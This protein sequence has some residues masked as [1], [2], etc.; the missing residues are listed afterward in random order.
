MAVK[1]RSAD[2]INSRTKR[3]RKVS[4]RE[5]LVRGLANASLKHVRVSPR[6]ARLVLNTIRGRQVEPALQILMF[7]KQRTSNLLAKLLRSAIANAKEH[8]GA[9]VDKL[10]VSSCFVDPGPT[11]KRSMPAAH[12]RANP[13]DKRS[14]HITIFLEQR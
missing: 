9:N 3:A 14:S 6:K 11:M 8:A 13:I 4:P 10:W 5:V 1:E 2:K 7:A 12:G